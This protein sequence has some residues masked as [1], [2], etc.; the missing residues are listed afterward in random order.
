MM[1]ARDR[2]VIVDDLALDTADTILDCFNS[3]R[4]PVSLRHVVP[5][6]TLR[7][8]TIRAVAIR[9][10]G[11]SRARVKDE[12]HLLKMRANPKFTKILVIVLVNEV[13]LQIEA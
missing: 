3:T 8:L 5:V 13:G 11:P 9:D 6:M 4:T 12:C 10:P 2:Y 1:R 7:T